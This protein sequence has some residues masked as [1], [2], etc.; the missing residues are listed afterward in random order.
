VSTDF[1]P[2]RNIFTDYV[3]SKKVASEGLVSLLLVD[4]ILISTKN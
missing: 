1:C 4:L 3:G 2:S